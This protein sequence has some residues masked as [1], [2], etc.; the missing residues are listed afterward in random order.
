[1][2]LDPLDYLQHILDEADYLMDRSRGLAKEDF[3]K[4]DTLKRAFARSF[5][6]IGEAVK[7]I[8]D[9]IRNKYAEIEW[10][11]IAGMRDKLIHDYFG[12]DYE[13]VWDAVKSKIPPLRE[14]IREILDRAAAQDRGPAN[15]S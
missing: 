6:I 4:D 9:E 5:E 3:I 15:D 12:V 10:K 13:I 8:P 7:R 2:S 14:G 11:A 1:M